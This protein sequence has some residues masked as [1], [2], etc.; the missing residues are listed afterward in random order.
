VRHCPIQ[1]PYYEIPPEFDVETVLILDAM[2]WGSDGDVHRAL[3]SV[4]AQLPSLQLFRIHHGRHVSSIPGPPVRRL[5]P[6]P[7]VHF[8]DLALPLQAGIRLDGFG[9]VFVNLRY[10][11]SLPDKLLFSGRSGATVYLFM[12]VAEA[13]GS[14]S[15]PAAEAWKRVLAMTRVADSRV[16]VVHD[17]SEAE[18]G[19]PS[20][21]FAALKDKIGDYAFDLAMEP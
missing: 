7:V 6:L 19:V 1:N 11:G 21:S 2:L 12:T 9:D 16:V 4:V 5:P 3:G 17:D 20:M 10:T 15:L 18:G 8:V 13:E 14:R